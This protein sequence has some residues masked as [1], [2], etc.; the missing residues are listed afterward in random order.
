MTGLNPLDFGASIQRESLANNSDA[1]GL[2]PLDFGA[3]IQRQTTAMRLT[4]RLNPLDFGASIQR[5]VNLGF[6]ENFGS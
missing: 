5:K 3:S 2:N 1:L 6:A 4:A